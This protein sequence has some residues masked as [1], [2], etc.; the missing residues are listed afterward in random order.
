MHL[1]T[2]HTVVGGNA[3]SMGRDGCENLVS[4]LEAWP[5]PV[6]DLSAFCN[7][8][9]SGD[10]EAGV[11]FCH[12]H[13]SS[14]SV[15]RKRWEQIVQSK[16]RASPKALDLLD[17]LLR[18]DHQ[19]RLTATEAMEHPYISVCVQKGLWLSGIAVYSRVCEQRP[20][21]YACVYEQR[22]ILT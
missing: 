15:P 13:L 11:S 21:A 8:A 6:V 18:Y 22:Q 4:G 19:Q 12:V 10:R 1:V 17:K 14:L 7:P 3:L 5:S 9:F 16:N 20:C 2:G